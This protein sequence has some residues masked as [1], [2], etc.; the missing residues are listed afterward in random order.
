[1]L[2][3]ASKGTVRSLSPG[4]WRKQTNEQTKTTKKSLNRAFSVFG[5]TGG[6]GGAG[7]LLRGRQMAHSTESCFTHGI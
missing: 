6:A 1:M 4:F 5:V 3:R 2:S 7:D